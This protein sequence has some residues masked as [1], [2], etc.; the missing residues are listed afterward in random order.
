MSGLTY[1]KNR[2]D[3][4]SAGAGATTNGLDGYRVVLPQSRIPT[5][6]YNILAD[7][8]TPMPPVLHPATHRPVGTITKRLSRA[9]ARLRRS[10]VSEARP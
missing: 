8:P 10:L 5:H 7:M 1:G 3:G 4:N 6:W 2:I 9:F